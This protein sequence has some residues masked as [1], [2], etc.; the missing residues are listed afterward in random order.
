MRNKLHNQIQNDGYSLH[1]KECK[2][3]F[4][5]SF[6]VQQYHAAIIFSISI[7]HKIVFLKAVLMYFKDQNCWTHTTE[8]ESGSAYTKLNM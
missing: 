3:H 8:N 7:R 2:L 6:F 1:K 4:S 5:L